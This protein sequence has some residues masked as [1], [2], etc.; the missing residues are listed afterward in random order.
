MFMHGVMEEKGRASIQ[1]V[2]GFKEEKGPQ[3]DGTMWT[4]KKLTQQ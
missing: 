4:N 3:K 2:E 1:T